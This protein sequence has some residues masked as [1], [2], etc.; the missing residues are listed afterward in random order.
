MHIDQ[1]GDNKKIS[2]YNCNKLLAMI[3]NDGFYEF[4]HSG[5]NIAITFPYG[6]ILCG[7]CRRLNILEPFSDNKKTIGLNIDYLK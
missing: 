1:S 5:K 7:R 3:N 2:C 6:S 4:E